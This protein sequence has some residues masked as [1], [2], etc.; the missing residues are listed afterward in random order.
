MRLSNVPRFLQTQT[1]K[2]VKKNTTCRHC[3]GDFLH[4][5]IYLVFGKSRNS[6]NKMNFAKVC[7]SKRDG[8]YTSKTRVNKVDNYEFEDA[9]DSS[10]DSE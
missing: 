7:R 6:C 3:G 2:T 5:N 1:D 8:N 4:A 10:S 9:D